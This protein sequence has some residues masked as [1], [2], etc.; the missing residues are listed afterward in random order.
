MYF[1]IYWLAGGDWFFTA[2]AVAGVFF[3]ARAVLR[4]I[5]GG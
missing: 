4:T 5:M 3:A 1:E 2:L